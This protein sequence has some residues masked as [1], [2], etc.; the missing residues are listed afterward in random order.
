MLA[1]LQ[2][3]VRVFFSMF[4]QERWSGCRRVS[5][6]AY[7]AVVLMSLRK[8]RTITHEYV[9]L[10]LNF[11]GVHA[12]LHYVSLFAVHPQTRGRMIAEEKFAFAGKS[13]ICNTGGIIDVL[14]A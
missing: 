9:V 2:S 6:K 4:G 1:R 7:L 5:D 14:L 10:G 11:L 3:E 13:I 8:K 12:L